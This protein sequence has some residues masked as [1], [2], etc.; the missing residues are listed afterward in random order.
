MRNHTTALLAVAGAAL[1]SLT[2]CT[3]TDEPAIDTAASSPAAEPTTTPTPA[4]SAELQ[5][6]V[7][8]YTAAYFQGASEVAYAVLSKRCQ[9]QITEDAYGAVVEQAKADYGQQTVKS[10]SV[11]KMAGDLARVSY[12]VSLPKFDQQGQAWVR[13]GGAWKYDAC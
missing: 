3:S 4:E 1:L 7:R 9:G 12:T 11:D 8:R 6:A 5:L 13:E 10:V 2:A